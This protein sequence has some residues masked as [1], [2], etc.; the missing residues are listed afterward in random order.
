MRRLVAWLTQRGVAVWFDEDI[1]TGERWESVLRER[2]ES[3]A[4]LVVVMSHAG[5]R[6]AVAD[7]SAWT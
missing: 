2:V 1:P 5:S 3:A 6:I 4:V 7:R